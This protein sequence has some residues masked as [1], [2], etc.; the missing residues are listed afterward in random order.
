[1]TIRDRLLS[2]YRQIINKNAASEDFFGQQADQAEATAKSM[3]E[4]AAEAHSARMDAQR[5]FVALKKR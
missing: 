1:M 3:R 5:S 4:K 2:L